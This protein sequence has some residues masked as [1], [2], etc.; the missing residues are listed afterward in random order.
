[1][2]AEP[3]APVVLRP[4]DLLQVT[5]WRQPEL[6]GEIPVGAD[7]TLAHP[8]YRELQVAG[9]PLDVVERRVREVIGRYEANP[10]F[11]LRPLFRVAVGGEV[12]APNLYSFPPDVTVQQAVALAGGPT[13]MGR[14]DRVQVIRDGEVIELDLT[15]HEDGAG[16]MPVRSGDQIL[17]ARRRE[18][19]F[20]Q[21]I[22]PASSLTAAV[23]SIVTL[24]TR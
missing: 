19:F 22:V 17:V 24:L 5:V 21:V 4:G 23:V 18:S 11:V 10:Y 16:E 2:N 9:V 12:G 8:L 13:D 7:G 15:R 6:S 1:M 20:R 14:I 3:Q